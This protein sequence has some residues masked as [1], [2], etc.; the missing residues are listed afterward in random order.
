MQNIFSIPIEILQLNDFNNEILINYAKQ[1]YNENKKYKDC[2]PYDLELKDL[3]SIVIQSAERFASNYTGNPNNKITIKKVWP[4]IHADKSLLTAH[5]H[6]DSFLSAVYYPKV[7]NEELIIQSPFSHG[8]LSHVNPDLIEKY[9]EYNSDNFFIPL[10]T[11][12]LVIFNA[13]LI[14]YIRPSNDE[15]ISIAFDL[16]LEK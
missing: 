8:H 10:K 14:H 6:R 9:N 5:A 1:K 15:R 4:N 11:G 13:M 2:S 16:E 3:N 12:M 7:N